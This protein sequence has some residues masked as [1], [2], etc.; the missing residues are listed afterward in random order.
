MKLKQMYSSKINMSLSAMDLSRQQT[1]WWSLSIITIRK[2]INYVYV[3]FIILNIS[4]F[5]SLIKR[6][7]SLQILIPNDRCYCI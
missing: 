7:C 6:L 5:S 2:L 3:S 4:F 1:E